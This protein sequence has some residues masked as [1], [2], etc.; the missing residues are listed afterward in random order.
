MRASRLISEFDMHLHQVV[1]AT[2]ETRR[3]YLYYVQLFLQNG[4]ADNSAVDPAR[5]KPSDIIRFIVRENGQRNIAW[6]KAMLTALRSYIRFL[7]IHGLGRPELVAAVP[8][9]P[10]WKL[11]TLPKYLTPVQLRKLLA[12]FDRTTANG[13]RDYAVALC[14]ARLGLRS[15][16]VARLTLDDIDWRAGVLRLAAG[17]GRRIGVAPLPCEVG[18]AIVAYLRNGRPAT[19]ERRIF[20]CHHLTL[21]APLCS[22]AVAAIVNRGFKRA[23]LAARGTHIFRH[24]VATR[25]IQRGQSIKEVADFLRH[26]NIDTTGIYAKVNIPM[27]REAAL[28]WPEEVIVP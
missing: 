20:V 27:L 26:R 15:Q 23:G 1:G 8:A 14:L 11:A 13:R 28:P 21:G 7:R 10:H 3:N 17:K 24:T 4:G 16:E 25:L 18:R 5:L 6:I 9:V 22:T 12:V 19:G 2:I